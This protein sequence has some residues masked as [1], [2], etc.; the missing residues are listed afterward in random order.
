[1]KLYVKL[2]AF[3]IIGIISN[4]YVGMSPLSPFSFYKPRQGVQNDYL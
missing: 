1:M 4:F 2:M 3:I